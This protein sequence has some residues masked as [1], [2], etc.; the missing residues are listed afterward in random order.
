MTVV[1]FAPRDLWI[2]TIQPRGSTPPRNDADREF[3]ARRQSR[4]Q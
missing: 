4:A 1:I 3:A 2:D